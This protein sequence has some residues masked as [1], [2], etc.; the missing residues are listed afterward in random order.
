M[1]AN[2][3]ADSKNAGEAVL[4]KLIAGWWKQATGDAKRGKKIPLLV[5]TRANE[6]VWVMME[7][8]VFAETESMKR[9]SAVMRV[10]NLR[11]MLWKEFLNKE[12][13]DI[14]VLL[15]GPHHG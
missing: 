10:G 7:T 11:V 15:K 5:M 2:M 12:Y 4:P 14:A 13:G 9:A 3:A 6:P 8:W 1:L